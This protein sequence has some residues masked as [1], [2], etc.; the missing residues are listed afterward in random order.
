MTGVSRMLPGKS[1]GP[2][3]SKNVFWGV[4][5]ANWGDFFVC[6]YNNVRTVKTRKRRLV[7]LVRVGGKVA[8][9]AEGGG[10]P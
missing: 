5:T 3:V 8:S 6:A 4:K 1:W 10:R 9:G 2:G 7:G